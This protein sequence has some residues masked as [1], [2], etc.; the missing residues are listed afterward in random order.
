MKKNLFLI[1]LAFAIY[2]INRLYSQGL[3]IE[4]ELPTEAGKNVTLAYH[5]LDKIYASTAASLNSE[6][7]GV[8]E[9]DT[10]IPQGLYKI[11]VDQDHHFDF[12]LGTDQQFS[13]RNTTFTAETAEIRG[14]VETEEFIEYM[15]YLNDLRKQ[16]ANLKSKINDATTQEEKNNLQE[17]INGLTPKL[18]QYWFNIN[19]KYPESFLSKFLLASYVPE[20]DISNAPAEIQANDSL[21]LLERFYY[22][23]KHF[24][25]YLDYTDESFLYTLIFKP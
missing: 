14:A 11:L 10:L 16:S 1:L 6:G 17:Q 4:I 9:I 15:R 21:L 2:P 7:R 8:F 18:Q 25:D 20:F 22:Q 13:I 12:L 24:W 23:Q 5:Y 3:K 19:D